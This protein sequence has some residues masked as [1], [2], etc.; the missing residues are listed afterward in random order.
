M[1]PIKLHV[2]KPKPTRGDWSF[3]R[4]ING[5]RL[6]ITDNSSIKTEADLC[7]Y[8]YRRWGTGRYQ[9]IAWQKGHEG[10]WLFWLGDIYENGFLRDTHKNKEVEKLQKEFD[11]AQT[12]EEKAEIEEEITMEKEIFGLEKSCKWRGPRGIKSLRPG[13]FHTFDEKFE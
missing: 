1:K 12:Y 2:K 3:Y 6:L 11:K 5:G 4:E 9:V 10:F 7:L 13:V 8:I